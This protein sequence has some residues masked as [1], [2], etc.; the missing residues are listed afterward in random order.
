MFDVN[1]EREIHGM[2]ICLS[3]SISSCSRPPC[4]LSTIKTVELEELNEKMQKCDVRL[5]HF[6]W[7]KEMVPLPLLM[8]CSVLLSLSFN[9]PELQNPKPQSA[10][11]LGPCESVF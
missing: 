4:S 10:C 8:Q 5:E 3:L 6:Q 7:L 1:V 9:M 2:S 11:P